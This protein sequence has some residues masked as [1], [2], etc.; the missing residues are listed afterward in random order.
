MLSKLDN[1]PV[2]SNGLSPLDNTVALFGSGLNGRFNSAD[3]FSEGH[4]RHSIP[5]LIAGSGGGKLKTD[6]E[7][8]LPAG[9]RYANLFETLLANVY[10]TPET[11][12]ANSTGVIESMIS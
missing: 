9:T 8:G 11:K 4:R 1:L 5:M 6:Q 2:E 7:V 10:C 3:G 12:F